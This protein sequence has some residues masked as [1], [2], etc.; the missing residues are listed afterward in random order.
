[1]E[2][3]IP[4]CAEIYQRSLGGRIYAVDISRPIDTTTDTAVNSLAS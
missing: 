3:W 2:F 4:A 1:M